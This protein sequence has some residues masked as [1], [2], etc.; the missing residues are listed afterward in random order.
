MSAMAPQLQA[1][2][3]WSLLEVIAWL[4]TDGRFKT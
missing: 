1:S 3:P 4:A 2:G